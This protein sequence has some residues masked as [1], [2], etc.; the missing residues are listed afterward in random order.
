MATAPAAVA[1]LKRH[2]A[3]EAL[4]EAHVGALVG[5]A[6]AWLVSDFC[7]YIVGA[8]LFVD[9]GMTLFPG[10]ATNG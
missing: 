5:K 9:G 8:T 7:D 1:R 10:F 3:I 4:L 6:A 2:P